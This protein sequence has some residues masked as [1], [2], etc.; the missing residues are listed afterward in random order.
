[1]KNFYVRIM[2]AAA[3]AAVL[4]AAVTG[5]GSQG[6]AG[7]GNGDA[8]AAK[9]AFLMPDIASTRYE[10]F[11]RPL[12]EAKV[13]ELCAGCTVVYSNA[14]AS[15]AKQQQQANSA[16]AQG[17]KA[18]VIDP[19]D[20]AAAATIVRLSQGAERADHRLRPAHPRQAPADYYVSFD[21][22]KIGSMIAQSLVDHLKSQ[23]RRRRTPAGQRLAYRRRGR[24]HQERHPLRH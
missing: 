6:S 8:S 20:S 5:C 4:G 24:A 9:I 15:A 21:N 22:E 1:M 23:R 12:F 17:V 18:I 11:D 3:T 13:K 14:N 7:A 10:L 16:L 2:T 19:V